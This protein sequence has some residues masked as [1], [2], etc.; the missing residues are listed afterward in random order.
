MLMEKAFDS[1]PKL[2]WMGGSMDIRMDGWE[3]KEKMCEG[4]GS[5]QT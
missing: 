4:R 2:A 1:W 5:L 3:R